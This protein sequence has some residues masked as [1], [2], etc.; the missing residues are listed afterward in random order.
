MGRVEKNKIKEKTKNRKV[1]RF[2]GK[3]FKFL[4]L[5]F[6]TFFLIAMMTVGVLVVKFKPMAVDIWNSANE[7]VASI[8]EGTFKDKT[9]T[10][11][12]DTNG[13][14]IKE[15][16]V[17]DYFYI[18]NE[19]ISQPI[20]DAVIAIE[21]VR[22]LEHQG[23]D[24]KAISR[25]FFELVKNNGHIT[26]G[27]STITQQLVKVQMLSLEK[28][29]NRKIEE[30]IISTKL[31]KLYSKEE[32]LEFYL[33][34]INYG[35]GAYGIE[36][37]SRTYFN[38]PSNELTL[39]EVAF[40]TA[41][42]NNPSVYNPVRNMDNTLERRNL[43]LS[44]M[45]TYGFI[46]EEDYQQA[47][48]QEIV[49]NMP[50]KEHEP[51]TYEV[52]FAISSATKI[53]MENEGFKFK[54]WFDTDAE[55]DK[56]WEE[57]NDLFLQLN[58]KI[59]NGGY[60]IYT[61]ID[62]AKQAELQKSINNKLAGYKGKN[63]ET[64]LYNLQSSGVMMD[65]ETGDV[66]AIVGGRE[67]SDIANTFNRA[68]LSYRQPGST[69]KPIV[70]YTPAFEKG[71]LA[72]SVMVDKPIKNGPQ[73]VDSRFRGNVTLRKAVEQSYNT[74]PFQLLINYGA[75]NMVSYLS[76]LEFSNLV[77]EDANP[78][79]AVGGF[80]YGTNTLEMAGAYSTIA[81]NGEYIKPTG[82][83]KMIDVTNTVIYENK[84]KKKR[85][86][87]AGSAYL[88]TDVLKGVITNGTGK[89]SAI[90]NIATAGKTGTT[91]DYK[92][93]WFAGYTP[94]YT[95]VVWVGEDIPKRL[96]DTELAKEIWT[97]FMLKSHKGLKEKD[98]KMPDRI[99]YMY[100]HP[101][102]GEVDKKDGRGWWRLELVPEIYYELQ[103]KR[104]AEARAKAERDRKEAERQR[105]EKIKQALE[106]A[107][108]TQEEEDKRELNAETYLSYLEE[109]HLYSEYD[110]ESVY[111]LMNET[112]LAIE[113]VVLE[114]PKKGFMKR[115]NKEA[116]RIEKERYVLENPVKEE[117]PIVEEKPIEPQ[118]P[119]ITDNP[120]NKNSNNGNNSNTSNTGNTNN[121]GNNNN[122]GNTNSG[123]SN[124]G[125]PNDNNTKPPKPNPNPN[126]ETPEKPTTPEN[127]NE[128]DNPEVPGN[129]GEIGEIEIPENEEKP[130]ETESEQSQNKRMDIEP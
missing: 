122:N 125:K 14:L 20:K 18:E 41:I 44:Q 115:Y 6:L 54:Y 52:S 35:N 49:L 68:Y 106:E 25:A 71:K 93:V 123:N 92:D 95:T 60:K 104:K 112:M 13:K 67:Q 128:T 64:G 82:I 59:R 61:T 108:I 129:S 87:D 98:F 36:T 51:D 113:S 62:M 110:Y 72:S 58:K 3:F 86:F 89:G 120:N 109:A 116:T 48:A 12:Y 79:V 26:Q 30:I 19:K 27:G 40:L 28:S 100:V 4:F 126:P 74:I 88:M 94:Y 127:P 81:R 31:E 96:T 24:F 42:P 55:R 38:K 76:K 45:K 37:A 22:F 97:D 56:Y 29:Y 84:H 102:T 103:E 8:N 10:M 17:N 16:A 117:E 105:L 11:I 83:K 130:S 53:L 121:N 101:R 107:G 57:Y 75:K 47:L 78:I 33:N 7:K 65:N 80:T 9:E 90:P 32:I 23:F 50:K 46:K 69:I 21:D 91:N 99:S 111:S 77:P 5:M 70:A 43:I 114:E 34:N 15:V 73:N 85:V 2:F 124:N 39:S 118:L 119:P 66:L 63:K 1:R